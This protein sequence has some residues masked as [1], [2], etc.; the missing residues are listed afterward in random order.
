M[1]AQ[2]TCQETAPRQESQRAKEKERVAVRE[3]EEEEENEVAKVE[4]NDV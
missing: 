1:A 4:V 2:D 3:E